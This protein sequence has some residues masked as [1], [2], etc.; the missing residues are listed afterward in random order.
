MWQRW[1]VSDW[2]GFGCNSSVRTCLKGMLDVPDG[3]WCIHGGY[4]SKYDM[5]VIRFS[6][7]ELPDILHKDDLIC[8]DCIDGLYEKGICVK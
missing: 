2:G 1:S 4:G 6:T 7:S 8:D 5:S 3:Q